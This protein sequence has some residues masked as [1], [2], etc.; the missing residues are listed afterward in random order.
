MKEGYYA[1][2]V[3]IGAHGGARIPVEGNQLE[4][5]LLN[6]D[7]LRNASMGKETGMGK[8][9][10]VYGGGNVA[11]DC[12]RTAKRL[13]AEEVHLSCL[14]AE[15][16]M[17]CDRIEIMEAREE[18][19]IVHDAHS[20]EKIVGTDSVKGVELAKI[21]SFTFDEQRRAV[22]EKEE[23]S[24]HVIDV[25]T[26]IFSVGQKPIIK[27][28]AGLPL[29]RGAYIVVK[30]GSVATEVDGVFAAGDV[31]YGTSSVIKA[32]A[33]G[34]NAAMEIDK[35]LGGDGDISEVLV[36]K[37]KADPY[38]GIIEGFGDM[39]RGVNATLDPKTRECGFDLVDLGISDDA[40]NFETNRCLQCD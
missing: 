12:A 6:I 14:E 7:F 28:E 22:L 32:M 38:I 11:F 15:E 24:E 13:G 40:I 35:Y 2:L 29:V 17:L 27:E 4:G 10:Y 19:V 36:P 23:G 20:L 3:T 8:K 30:E 9:V 1:V 26:V 37:E 33:S 39:N 5:V 18:G 31:V 25:D 16:G 21:K 34:R